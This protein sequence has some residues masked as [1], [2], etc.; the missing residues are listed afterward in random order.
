MVVAD[1]YARMMAALLPQGRLWDR[2]SGMLMDVLLG[3]AV[4]LERLHGR[5]QDLLKEIDPT[6]ATE[7]LPDYEAELGL[8]SA[9]TLAERRARIVARLVQRQRY[10]PVDFQTTLAPLLGQAA[11]DVVVIE[12]THAFAASIGDDREIFRFFVYRDPTL[13]GAYFLASGQAQLDRMKPSHTVGHVI[14]SVDFRYDD[15]HSLYDRDLL[16][17]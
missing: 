6:T 16:G 15:P 1:S 5:V 10:R 2:V 9:P 13:P 11:A 4:E 12:R 17:A 14:E 3:C 7:L 8:G